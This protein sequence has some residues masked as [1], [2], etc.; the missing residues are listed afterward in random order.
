M[1]LEDANE[2]QSELVNKLSG[3][4]TEKT[5]FEKKY[6]PNYVAFFLMQEKKEKENI[7]IKK[8]R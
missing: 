2:E 5:P 1:S 4:N 3:M 8:S 7:S 6:F